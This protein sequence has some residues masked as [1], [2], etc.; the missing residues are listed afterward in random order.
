[1]GAGNDTFV[2]NP[3]DGSDTVEGQAG[4]DTLQFNGANVAE[5]VDISANG[6]RVRFFRDVANITMDLNGVE[7][8]NFNALGGADNI[9]VGDLTGTNVQQVN[10][11]LGANDGAAD[12]VTINGTA[13]NDVIMVTENNGVIT[14]TG[15]SEVVNITDAGTGDKLVINGLGG[16]D[17]IQASGLRGGIT[18]VANGGDGNDVLIGSPG[19]DELHGGNGDDILIGGGGQDILDGG[20]GDNV[21]LNGGAAPP[22]NPTPT[23]PTPPDPT[24]TPT[25]APDPTPT[26]TPVPPIG[27]IG[28]FSGAALL[29]QAMASTLVPAGGGLGGMPTPDPHTTQP[30]LAPP[31]HA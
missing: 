20:P 1:M 7:N 18:L 9:T 12:T 13:G 14:I 19:N 28:G 29:S 8:I 22:P 4:I 25:P 30:V 21:V 10:L 31:Q 6:S 16:D 26:P 23:D 15:L 17:V 2:W 5:N 27:G 3:G 24:P 11:D